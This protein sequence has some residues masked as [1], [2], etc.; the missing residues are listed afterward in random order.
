MQCSLCEGSPDSIKH[1]FFECSYAE[2]IWSELRKKSQLV[3]M[4]YEWEAIL[5]KMVSLPCNN[6]ISS[7]VR[8]IVIAASVYFIWMERNKRLFT[9]EKRNPNELLKTIIEHVRL[10]LASLKVKSS[11]QIYKVSKEWQIQMN[12]RRQDY[13]YLFWF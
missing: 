11:V 1:L 6:S 5:H 9:R 7:V 8:R 4:P 13:M 2:K 12:V 3:D 10:K